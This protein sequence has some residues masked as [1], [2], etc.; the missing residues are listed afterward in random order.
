MPTMQTLPSMP[1][2]SP[3]T[4]HTLAAREQT[5]P[6]FQFRLRTLMGFTAGVSVVCAILRAIGIEP[7]QV[8]IGVSLSAAGAGIAIA[9]IETTR[10][11]S[12]WNDRSRR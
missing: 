10:S 7:V 12:G 11:L 6:P 3:R 5:P 8:L 4:E 2:T 1:L 9:W